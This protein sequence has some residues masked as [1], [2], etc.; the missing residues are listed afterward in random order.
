MLSPPSPPLPPHRRL[1][2]AQPPPALPFRVGHGFD[3]HRLAPGLPLWLAGLLIPSEKGCEAHSD[4][5]VLLHC[6]TDAVL[7]ALALPDIGQLFPDTDPRWKGA[8]SHVFLTEAVRLCHDAGFEV[9]NVD[10]T[11]IAERPKLSPHKAAMRAS[12]A[13]LL[14]CH[15]SCVNIKAKTHEKVDAVGEQRAI[16]CH[17][18]IL[19]IRKA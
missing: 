5:D 11:V 16:E 17:A 6:V 13:A 9:G 14:A 19:L 12:L 1:P 15:E 3:L 18:V 7:G 4:G 8:A 2:A 10:V